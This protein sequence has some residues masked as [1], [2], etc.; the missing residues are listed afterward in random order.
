MPKNTKVHRCVDALK[1]AKKESGSAI[2]ICQASTKQGYA[3]GKKL[4]NKNKQTNE[5]RSTGGPETGARVGAWVDKQHTITPEK[6][7]QI[8]R[9]HNKVAKKKTKSTDGKRPPRAK[10][11]A[12]S[13][14]FINKLGPD[15]RRFL[16]PEN[17]S[18]AYKQIGLVLA[19]ALGHRVDEA[20]PLV[21]LGLAARG[22]VGGITK[23]A[24]AAARL[25][26]QGI[27][28]GAKVAGQATKNAAV[29]AKDAAVAAGKDKAIKVA[30]DKAIKVARNTATNVRNR[31][32]SDEEALND[33]QH[34]SKSMNKYVRKL[35]ESTEDTGERKD[36]PGLSLAYARLAH[37]FLE[38]EFTAR[39]TTARETRK[40][41]GEA[42][43]RDVATRRKGKST[44]SPTNSRREIGMQQVAA[45][46]FRDSQKA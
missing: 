8:D 4:M 16:N 33:L 24:A 31:V 42:L 21:A 13:K 39:A 46:G 2:A 27:K 20:G 3:T 36:Y 25:L 30:Q 11:K 40:K 29:G 10:Q 32:V 6:R 23:G 44:I 41:A 9:I 17:S 1:K 7:D 22:V 43:R 19:E 34:E 18:R 26:A 14:N 38:N 35:K 12:R 5:G 28:S 37:L 15:A 45:R